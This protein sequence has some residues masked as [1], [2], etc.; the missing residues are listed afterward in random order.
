MTS[1]PFRYWGS[2]VRM[3]PGIV[4]RLPPHDHFVEVC[5]GSAAVLMN[6]PQSVYET[7]N[8]TYAEVV[9]FF[10]VLRDPRKSAALVDMV[11]FTPYSSDD[12]KAAFER[13]SSDVDAAYKFFVRSQMAVVPGR[14]GWSYGVGGKSAAKANK[15]GRWATMPAHLKACAARFQRVQVMNLPAVDLLAKLDAPGTLFFVDPPYLPES[16]PKSVGSASAYTEDQFDHVGFVEACGRLKHADVLVT[17]YPHQF[18]DDG[19]WR[20]LGDFRG[21]ANVANGPGRR[22]AVERLYILD[23]SR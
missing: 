6:K 19:P 17:H 20:V 1:A 12:F 14:T 11:A 8:D 15:P 10:R 18:Y 16:R 21:H 2:K 9:N 22:V 5:C 23:K 4:E 3:A 7:V 13:A